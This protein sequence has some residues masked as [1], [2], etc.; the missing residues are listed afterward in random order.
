MVLT[1]THPG[2]ELAEL[3]W[4]GGLPHDHRPPP[5]TAHRPPLPAVSCSHEASGLGGLDLDELVE[6]V[7]FEVRRLSTR[8]SKRYPRWE[9]CHE[10]VPPEDRVSPRDCLTCA[11][12]LLGFVC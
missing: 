1:V 3:A 6:A 7:A 4:W 8:R 2:F 12:T 5:P 10:M 11:A 9:L